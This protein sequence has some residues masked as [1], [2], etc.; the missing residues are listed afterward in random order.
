M[1][2]YI[3]RSIIS[4]N[5]LQSVRHFQT[6]IWFH[7]FFIDYSTLFHYGKRSHNTSLAF[8]RR[9]ILGLPIGLHVKRHSHTYSLHI[10]ISFRGVPLF[11]E[12]ME[13][14]CSHC[15]VN[16]RHFYFQHSSEY[17]Q[18]RLRGEWLSSVPFRYSPLYIAEGNNPS[19]RN[20]QIK[21]RNLF[22]SGS[23]GIH[24]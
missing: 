17:I 19:L 16:R 11:L 20:P 13:E 10:Y 5:F 2:R 7:E 9:Y 4:V 21:I 8:I 18:I 12:E 24:T 23:Y 14:N 3:L 15:D 1:N 22:F 6:K